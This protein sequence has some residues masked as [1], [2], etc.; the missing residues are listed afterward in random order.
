MAQGI[1]LDRSKLLEVSRRSRILDYH[2]PFGLC[3]VGAN[4]P[5][6]LVQDFRSEDHDRYLYYYRQLR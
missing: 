1:L 3:L 5:A 4:R 2:Q 6:G